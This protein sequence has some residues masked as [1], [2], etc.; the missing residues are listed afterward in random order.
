MSYVK[1][2]SQMSGLGAFPSITGLVQMATSTLPAAGP[3][4]QQ[5]G[6]VAQQAAPVLVQD[7]N[8]VVHQVVPGTQPVIGGQVVPPHVP[9]V[10]QACQA[11]MVVGAGSGL[12]L[13]A[14][15]G[16][17][18]GLVMDCPVKGALIGGG[19]TALLGGYAGCS[20]MEQAYP[21]I[22]ASM[23]PSV[24]VNVNVPSPPSVAGWY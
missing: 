21:E 23:V 18:V 22:V 1:P 19:L 24:N 8:G 2:Y 14:V 10:E 4:A 13:G 9:T 7:A 15:A 5:A 6:A 11:G 12:A 20:I 3:Y 16:L 17:V